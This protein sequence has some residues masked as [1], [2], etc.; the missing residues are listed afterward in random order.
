MQ[1]PPEIPKE[2]DEALTNWMADRITDGL[3]DPIT[4]FKSDK[5][6]DAIFERAAEMAGVHVTM[7]KASRA[8]LNEPGPGGC[9]ARWYRYYMNQWR[10][11]GHPPKF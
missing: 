5:V 11:D 4:G 6:M 9:S 2:E 10:K 1:E 7:A 8:M 3:R